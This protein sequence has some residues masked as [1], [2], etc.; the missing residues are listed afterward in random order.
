MK[1]FTTALAAFMAGSAM[2]AP[3]VEPRNQ[4]C[5]CATT[6]TV[7]PTVT[8]VLPVSTPCLTLTNSLVHATGLPKPGKH[9]EVDTTVVVTAV[10]HTVV[11]VQ[12]LVKADLKLIGG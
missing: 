8:E 6:V 4:V 11:E 10:V 5:N 12:A 1:F 3:A 2:A 9:N 7:A